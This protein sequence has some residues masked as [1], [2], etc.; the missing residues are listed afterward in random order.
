MQYPFVCSYFITLTLKGP[1]FLPYQTLQ[2]P[3]LYSVIITQFS[4]AFEKGGR[5]AHTDEVYFLH[6][7][8]TLSLVSSIWH[9]NTQLPC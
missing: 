9:S 8:P 1:I 6:L 4:W 5:G 7:Y 2:S 3:H